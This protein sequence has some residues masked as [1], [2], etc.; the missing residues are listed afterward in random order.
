MEYNPYKEVARNENVYLEGSVLSG[1]AFTQALFGKGKE[2]KR[3]VTPR[4]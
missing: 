1:A 2:I 4:S 3:D